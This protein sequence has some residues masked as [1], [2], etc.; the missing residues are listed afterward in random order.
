VAFS[1]DGAVLASASRDG[2]VRIWDAVRG[3]LRE[4]VYTGSTV[5]RLSFSD[6]GA[7]LVTDKGT[8][9]FITPS[10]TV[11]PSQQH[12]SEH[13]FV[14]EQW[15]TW[16][17]ERMLWLP[18]DHRPNCVATSGSVVVFGYQSGRV[19]IMGFAFPG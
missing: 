14:Q 7:F 1:P 5:T 3:V 8:L 2:T 11:V 17:K 18:P 4:T 6:D 13:I 10:P 19:S 15:V 9:P 12:L 16:Q